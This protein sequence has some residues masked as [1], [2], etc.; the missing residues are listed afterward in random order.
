MPKE[1]GLVCGAKVNLLKSFG[2]WATTIKGM[3]ACNCPVYHIN[4]SALRWTPNDTPPAIGG[5]ALGPFVIIH[6]LSCRIT[7]GFLEGPRHV[8]CSGHQNWSM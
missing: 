7:C 3:P 2:S 5:G 6:R 4:I 8:T 1:L